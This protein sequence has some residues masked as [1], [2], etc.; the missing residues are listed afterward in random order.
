MKKLLAVLLAVIMVL[1]LAAC[2]PG[3]S[4]DKNKNKGEISVLY[5][6]FSDAYIST[7]RTAMDKILTDGGYTFNDYDANGNQ[8]TQTEQVQT[9][10]AKGCSMLIV[11]VVDTGSQPRT[12][13]TSP[14]RRTFPSYS[15]TALSIRRLSRAMINAYSSAQIMSRPAIC[16]AR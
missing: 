13:S 4:G 2:K 6:S 10:L 9:A 8:T 3:D 14:R 11:N 16:R 1:G 5:Y 15:S 12:S 7:V